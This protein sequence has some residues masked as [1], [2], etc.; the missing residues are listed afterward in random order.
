MAAG[1]AVSIPAFFGAFGSYAQAFSPYLA[2]TIAFVLALATK[3][4]YHIAREGSTSEIL[5]SDESRYALTTC[6]QCGQEFEAPD[7]AHCTFHETP[8]CT[9]EKTCHDVCKK[10]L[11]MGRKPGME[12]T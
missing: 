7:M 8:I 11:E 6:G 5:E 12:S 1:V 3:G 4:K 2:L 9:L 10:P